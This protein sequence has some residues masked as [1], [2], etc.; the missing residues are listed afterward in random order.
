MNTDLQSDTGAEREP[1][2][3]RAAEPVPHPAPHREVKAAEPVTTGAEPHTAPHDE[4][5]NVVH[6][7][8]RANPSRT[9][10]IDA[11]ANALG[12]RVAKLFYKHVPDEIG[13]RLNPR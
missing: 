3:R 6:D 10:S 7:L 2:E 9:V 11:L 1:E 5:I 12:D 13:N 4:I 8:M